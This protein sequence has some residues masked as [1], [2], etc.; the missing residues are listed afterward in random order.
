MKVCSY[1]LK[2]IKNRNDEWFTECQKPVWT[3]G[4]W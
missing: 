3:D 1:V 4:F 2:R